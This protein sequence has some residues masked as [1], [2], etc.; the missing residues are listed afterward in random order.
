MPDLYLGLMSGTSMDGVDVALVDF[1]KIEPE[2]IAFDTFPYPARLHRH[3][4]QLCDPQN[5]EIVAMG[6]AD[7]AV[8]RVSANAIHSVLSN[9]NISAKQIVAIGSHGQTIR[10]HPDGPNGFTIQIGDPNTLAVMTGIDVVADF[11][12]KD[13]ALGGQGAP[14][15]PAFHQAVFRHSQHSRVILNIGGIAN[16]SHL[17]ASIKEPVIGFDIGP[18]NTL[19]DLWCE[20][21]LH[22][23]YDENGQWAAQGNVSAELLSRMLDEPFFKLS[24][25]KSTGRELFNLH[26]LDDHLKALSSTLSPECVQATLANLTSISIAAEIQK[27]Y[28]VEQV[29][30]CGGGVKNDFLMKCLENELV[31]CDILTTG[32][33]GID[34]DAVEAAAF[35]WL[36]KEF[37][38]KSPSNLPSVTGASR[39]AVLGALY[40]AK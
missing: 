40:L 5:N 9:H 31:E 19:M 36:A 10:H 37:M 16:I 21:H 18:G 8:A 33:L 1:G 38:H 6:R 17:P 7:R 24:A 13:I 30:L 11:R 12:R 34:P 39:E 25:P 29:Y 4:H 3:L 35:A 27:L 32:D 23:P 22:Q 26:W 14:L 2:V 20:R 15:T 28:N